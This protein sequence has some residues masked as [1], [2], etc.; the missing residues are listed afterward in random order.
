MAAL[1]ACTQSC[2]E[3]CRGAKTELDLRVTAAASRGLAVEGHVHDGCL[4]YAFPG[5]SPW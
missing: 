4:G 2:G 3:F 1:D 5:S